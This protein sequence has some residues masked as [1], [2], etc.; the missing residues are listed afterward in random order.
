MKRDK[1]FYLVRRER[2]NNE[3]GS[4]LEIMRAVEA[5]MTDAHWKEIFEAMFA[6]TWRQQRHE[7]TERASRVIKE[8]GRARAESRKNMKVAVVKLKFALMDHMLSNGKLLRYATFGDVRKEGGWLTAIGKL[9][10]PDNAV[11][12]KH[13]TESNLVALRGRNRKAA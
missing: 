6:L 10:F 9:D 11:V 1:F 13:L 12:G 7:I 8:T 3:R 5:G 2:L 4:E